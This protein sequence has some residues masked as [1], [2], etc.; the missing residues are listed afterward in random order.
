MID[1]MDKTT[2]NK[3]RFVRDWNWSVYLLFI[4]NAVWCCS[5][6][7]ILSSCGHSSVFVERV[8]WGG[9]AEGETGVTVWCGRSPPSPCWAAPSD[10]SLSMSSKGLYPTN[11]NINVTT[12]TLSCPQTCWRWTKPVLQSKHTD[13]YVKDAN[14]H[15]THRPSST[16][17]LDKP[18][19]DKTETFIP[20]TE[21]PT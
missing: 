15:V 2:K 21:T 10:P 6:N 9:G 17:L 3:I 11:H 12:Q 14:Q 19:T 1:I 20:E 13:C 7:M 8:G 16:V 18:E 5:F 4:F